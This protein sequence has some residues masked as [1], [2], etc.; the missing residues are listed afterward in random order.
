MK[1][2]F[3]LTK[4]L[5]VALMLCVG[6][7]NAWAETVGST[8]DAYLANKSTSITLADGESVS[9]V[10]SQA[11]AATYNSQ[12][13]VLIAENTSGTRLVE[14][15]QC[16]YEVVSDG[17]TGITNDFTDDTWTNF[18]TLMNGATVNMTVGYSE[19]TLTMTSTITASDATEYSYG[20]TKA[21]DGT[22][23]SV[24]V[25]LSEYAAKLSIGK[26]AITKGTVTTTTFDFTSFAAS[27]TNVLI[28]GDAVGYVYRQK[29]Y[30]P[31]NFT[32]QFDSRFSFRYGSDAGQT[33]LNS[34]GLTLTNGNMF[35]IHSLSKGDQMSFSFSG[36]G[37]LKV[38]HNASGAHDDWIRL[39]QDGTEMAINTDL[40]SGTT[41]YSWNGERVGF[42]INDNTVTISSAT[43]KHNTSAQYASL[44][45]LWESYAD[46]HKAAEASDA[47]TA[48]KTAIDAAK[49]VIDD[50]DAT[51]DD[52]TDGI[53]AL[54]EAYDVYVASLGNTTF[55]ISSTDVV[56]HGV[57]VKCVTGITMT[58]GGGVDD[59]WTFEDVTD[60]GTR[61][62]TGSRAT[63]SN[64]IPTA[65]T[66]YTFT[67]TITG[68]LKIKLL[69]Y[70]GNNS[71]TRI[72]ADLSDG[73]TVNEIVLSK[74]YKVWDVDFG[75]LTPGKTYYFYCTQANG[76]D[77]PGIS[78]FTY[79]PT[80]SK[81]ISSA[82]WATYCSPYALDLANATGL[83]DAFIIT[84][85]AGG[86]L[87]KT[88]V[89]SGTVP[90]N[91]GLLLKGDEGTATIPVVASSSTN[92]S[93]NKLVGVT[94]E[95]VL[96]LDD[97]DDGTAD[98]SV[99]VLLKENDVLGFY[100]TTTTSFT[101]GANTAYLPS[102]FAGGAA[103]S[104]YFFDSITGVEA[105]DAAAEAAQKDGK[106]VI[107]GQLVIFK[108]GKKF[109]AN[110]TEIK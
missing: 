14:L 78:G 26:V 65:G 18:L 24:V 86:V 100:Q 107:N 97:N 10:F 58:Y 66:F 40:V 93:A 5:L 104:A 64:K 29:V 27:E 25:Y 82:G 109:N 68:V 56:R 99:Y 37:K 50:A 95:T 30:Y 35:S 63:V 106:F 59:T 48:L 41:Y 17:S 67:P 53:I 92:V 52:Y 57:N 69:G 55:N 44:F 12:G 9:Y 19:G 8:T 60:R 84:G 94:A 96:D 110:G 42:R 74:A 22:P 47:K 87:T 23:E 4:T 62:H 28:A 2:F 38:T 88:S 89:K 36:S 1:K 101:V 21:I 72:K 103:R 51:D 45:N 13:F 7:S 32:N 108:N 85:G 91:T 49:T 11:T 16:N 70:A 33:K 20:Y 61:F 31:S 39:S 102:D 76:T 6:A 98:K 81:A 71:T 80:V 43:I 105:V 34:S 77:D 90:A 75:V 46:I 79:E 54:R 3:L 83:T 15:Q 73:T